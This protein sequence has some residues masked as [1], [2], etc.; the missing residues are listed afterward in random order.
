[1]IVHWYGLKA[2]TKLVLIITK[3]H[4]FLDGALK[5]LKEYFDD[6]RPGLS[7]FANNPKEVNMVLKLF[8]ITSYF[9]V[10]FFFYRVLSQ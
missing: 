6:T 7:G 3:Y 5:L 8:R 10:N 4:S 9:L 1:M 2:P